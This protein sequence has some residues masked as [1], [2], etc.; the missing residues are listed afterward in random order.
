MSFIFLT[1][2]VCSLLL[3]FVLTRYVRNLAVARGWAATPPMPHHIHA[4]PIP[5][6][7]GVGIYLSV[8]LITGLMLVGAKLFNYDIGP[9]Q[10][11]ALYILLA[12]TIVFV[13][14]F[15]DDIYSVSPYIKF[16]T[17]TLGALVLY[18][19]G[20][21]VGGLPPLLGGYD[22]G[23]WLSL[24]LT[25]LWVLWITN[26]FNLID[27]IDGLAAGSALFSTLTVFVIALISGNNMT[28]LLAII[29]GGAILGFL[30]FNF[31]PATI[32]LGDCGSLFLG[33]MLSALALVGSQKASTVFAVAVPVVS[34][35]LPVLETLISI[36][37]RFLS[38]KPLFSPDRDHIHHKLL[39]R[40][41]SQRQVVI[42]LYGVSAICGLL[43]LFLLAPGGA[44]VAVVLFVLGAGIW[45]GVQHLGYHEFYELRRVANRTMSQKRIIVNN[46]SI[47]RAVAE[48]P[49]AENLL[50]LCSILETAF[51]SNDFD[52]FHLS[53]APRAAGTQFMTDDPEL[54]GR[55]N[56]IW[57]KPAGGRSIDTESL[58]H[59]TLV[60][61][62]MTKEGSNG[63]FLLYRASNERP[64]LVDVNLLTLEFQVALSKAVDRIVAKPKRQQVMKQSSLV[65]GKAVAFVPEVISKS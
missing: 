51:E 45:I 16:A 56:Y 7:G 22:P 26:A 8:A 49:K 61:Q 2:F 18:L 38:G 4:N 58:P 5:R 25:I 10:H 9:I 6:L 60:L 11:R 46:L 52:S 32:F 30:R 42:T 63:Y 27:G 59:W 20:I 28:S 31:N 57:H 40:G 41:L 53:L 43:S 17:Q 15:Y 12:G 14:G 47:R 33:F 64:L 39:D 35:G 65:Q 1:A 19:S 24:P 62:L 13:L 36:A 48:L 37:R 54:T 21:H 44:P 23:W 29:M 55:H 50:D 34:F 3:S